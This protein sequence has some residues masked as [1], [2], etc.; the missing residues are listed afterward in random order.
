MPPRKCGGWIKSYLEKSWCGRRIERI[1]RVASDAQGQLLVAS[2]G[3]AHHRIV[4]RHLAFFSYRLPLVDKPSAERL[5][6]ELARIRY[7][8][9][10]QRFQHLFSLGGL[11]SPAGRFG[12]W[13]I[14]RGCSSIRPDRQHVGTRGRDVHINEFSIAVPQRQLWVGL[15]VQILPFDRLYTSAVARAGW[16]SGQVALALARAALQFIECG[17]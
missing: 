1:A 3:G 8:V 6:G 10:E 12:L 7:A 17:N 5:V 14:S 4:T 11:G 2:T 15:Q 9:G 16:A 13:R